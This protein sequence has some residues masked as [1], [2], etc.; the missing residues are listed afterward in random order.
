[1]THKFGVGQLVRPRE[2]LLENT[3]I[4]EIPRLLPSGPDDEPLYRIKVATGPIQRVVGEA[5]IVLASASSQGEC[6]GNLRSA[7]CGLRDE[8]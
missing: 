5:D 2:R 6:H 3:G 8:A 7:A 1:M 4:Y